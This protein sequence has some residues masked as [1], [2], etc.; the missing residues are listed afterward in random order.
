M[1]TDIEEAH[2]FLEERGV[3][4]TGPQHFVDG[5]MTPGADPNRAS[6]GSFVFFDD[7]DG[8]SWALQ[9]VAQPAR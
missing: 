4:S 5:Q 9:E 1:V 2:A 3:A 8:N 7:P 6:Y